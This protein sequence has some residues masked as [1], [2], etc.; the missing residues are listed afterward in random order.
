MGK[1]VLSGLLVLSLIGTPIADLGFMHAGN[2][3]W[4]PHARLHAVWSV[5]HTMA[6]QMLALGILWLGPN[7]G[8][9]FSIRISVLVLG[10][11]IASF[12]LSL[13]AGPLFGASI[14]PDLPQESMP[15]TLLGLD[16]NVV[17]MLIATPL[18]AWAW[19]LCERDAAAQT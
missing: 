12:F 8:S 14:V 6:V 13:A 16:G 7:A 9:V 4:P 18:L 1:V 5:F 17:S 3:A 19:W 11:Y 10:A 15:P 2:E